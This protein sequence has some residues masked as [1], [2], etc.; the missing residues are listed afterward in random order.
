[1][2]W[3]GEGWHKGERQAGAKKP[4]AS[5]DKNRRNIPPPPD[6]TSANE[7][8]LASPLPYKGR[9]VDRSAAEM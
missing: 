9:N 1:M 5:R 6:F 4:P 3:S 8:A 2:S 7:E